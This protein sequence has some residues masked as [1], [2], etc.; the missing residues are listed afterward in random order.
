[1]FICDEHLY[2]LDKGKMTSHQLPHLVKLYQDAGRCLCCNKHDHSNCCKLEKTS[3]QSEF[4]TTNHNYSS[5]LSVDK[6]VSDNLS[7]QM[8]GSVTNFV[9]PQGYKFYR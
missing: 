9:Y 4:M 5:P 3:R 6:S 7:Y 1:M 2:Q 8:L